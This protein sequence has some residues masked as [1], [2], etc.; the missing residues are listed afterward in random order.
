MK[1]VFFALIA[2]L[3]V[4]SAVAAQTA[5]A[6]QK[7]STDKYQKVAGLTAA[8]QQQLQK[9]KTDA[10][11]KRDAIQNNTALSKADRN[12]QI[13]QLNEQEHQQRLAVLTPDQQQQLKQTHKIKAAKP[14]AKP[15]PTPAA[16]Q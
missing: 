6:K 16:K 4:S 12:K 5:P 8:Q 15:A 1:R 3:L 9:I 2:G 7:Q 11:I 10:K 14:V 13:Q